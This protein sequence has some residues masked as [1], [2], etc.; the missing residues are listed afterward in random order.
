M[1]PIFVTEEHN[2]VT[3]KMQITAK[4]TSVGYKSDEA[5]ALEKVIPKLNI[6]EGYFLLNDGRFYLVWRTVAR[7]LFERVHLGKS[8]L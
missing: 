7:V 1:T 5:L 2:L 4:W 6:W 3:I 8:P